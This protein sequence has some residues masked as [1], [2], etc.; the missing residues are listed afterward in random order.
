MADVKTETGK[1]TP[2]PAT[3]K[4]VS[5]EEKKTVLGAGGG[6]QTED[7][8]KAQEPAKTEVPKTEEK[9]TV[10]PEKYEL[11]LPEGSLLDAKASER[12]AAYAKSQ[13]LSNEQAQALLE[14]EHGAVSLF[15]EGQKA[16]LTRL[17]KEWVAT[18]TGD[19]EIGGTDEN[20]KKNVTLAR[21]VIARFSSDGFLDALDKTGLGNHP[22]LIRTFVRIGKMVGEDKLVIANSQAATKL[23]PEELFYSKGKQGE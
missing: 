22:E 11:K 2:A 23:T 3:D 12:I 17:G 19:K 21:R 5:T 15:A 8:T 14:R 18:A 16:E 7:K 4:T 1:E 10:V 6:A 13:G 9:K 20:F